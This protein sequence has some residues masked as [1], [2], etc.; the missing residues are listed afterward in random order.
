MKGLLRYFLFI[1]LTIGMCSIPGCI[2]F[3][4][5]YL[6]TIILIIIG[7]LGAYHY[8]KIDRAKGYEI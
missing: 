7:G 5:G 2:E 1:I 4:E 3:E 6:Q 8:Y